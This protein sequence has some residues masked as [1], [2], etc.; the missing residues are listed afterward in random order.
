MVRK[1]IP[2]AVVDKVAR[3]LFTLHTH[4]EG[5]RMLERMELS[6]FEPANDATYEPVRR[7]LDTF[8]KEIRA[9]QECS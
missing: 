5:R 8:E 1:D 3:L 2:Q 4:E 6:R 9:P 7:F